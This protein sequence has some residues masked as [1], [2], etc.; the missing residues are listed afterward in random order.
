MST[1]YYIKGYTDPDVDKDSPEWHIGKR[2]GAGI[3]KTN[4]TWAIDPTDLVSRLNSLGLN[5]QLLD[6]CIISCE[7]EYSLHEFLME[8]VNKATLVF[9]NAIGFKFS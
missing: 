2:T 4:F 6:K 7:R 1:N 8:V 5:D 9:E 3:G